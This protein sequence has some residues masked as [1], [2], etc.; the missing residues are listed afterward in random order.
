[1]LTVATAAHGGR[2]PFRPDLAAR[3]ELPVRPSAPA[4]PPPRTA[5]PGAPLDVRPARLRDAAGLHALS[6]AFVRSGALRARPA[7]HYLDHV[8]EF[9]VAGGGGGA[10][11]GLHG[12]L[13]L[14]A[15]GPATAVL[16]NFCVAPGSQGRG[17]GSLLLSAAY[18]RARRCGVR[19]MFTAT[20][21][22]AA[23]FLRHGFV[24]CAPADAPAGWAA[25]LDPDRGSRVLRLT[26]R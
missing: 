14:R 10:G 5:A 17:V 22:S 1:M 12:C 8:G 15:E 20:T 3:P 25:A 9:L 19:V 13:A 2:A 6:R 24:P 16:Y 23:L 21:G 4:A 11:E 26:V 18:A 7:D